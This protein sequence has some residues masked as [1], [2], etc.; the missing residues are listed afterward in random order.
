MRHKLIPLFLLS[1]L[2][3]LALACS[4][5]GPTTQPPAVNQPASTV[6]VQ[7]TVNAAL[8]A[9]QAAVGSPTPNTQATV[10]AAIAATQSAAVAVQATV[11]VA[12]QATAAAMPTPVP[13]SNYAEM[14]EEELAALIDQAVA[15]ATA[16]ALQA[17]AAS[18]QAAADSQMSPEEVQAVQVY[19][20]GADA[21]IAYAQQAVNAYNQYYGELATETVAAMQAIEQDLNTLATNT[22]AI[23]TSLQQMNTTLQQGQS[24]AQ[25]TITQIQTTAQ[26]LG[27][28][29]QEAQAQVKTWS[30]T[31][32]S[33][34]DTR[35]NAALNVQP[36]E[37]P[38]NPLAALGAAFD[39]LDTVQGALQ[40]NKINKD[41]LAA[42]ALKGANATAGLNR[43]GDAQHKKFSG[44]INQ[45][46]N[47]LARGQNPQARS[48]T[49]NFQK[50]LGNRPANLPKPKRR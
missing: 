46:T 43:H 8:A 2:I 35:A 37:I 23:N 1:V 24:L 49:K 20:N 3:I 5:S 6:D 42:I 30:S 25:D 22:A 32:K 41:E 38:E 18:T 10:D 9:T 36:D 34:M 19:V 29:A 13:T 21:A 7:A 28:S 45:I 44:D 26:T 16:A 48:S 17:S 50:S 14:S 39:Y 12:V 47:H 11:N 33:E 31:V 15:E 27:Q 4:N 40:D